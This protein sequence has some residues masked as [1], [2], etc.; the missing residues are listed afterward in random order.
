[1]RE[2]PNFMA[3]DPERDILGKILAIN[4]ED[5]TVKIRNLPKTY[6][7]M[8]KNCWILEGTQKRDVTG[9]EI[10]EGQ[11]LKIEDSITPSVGLSPGFVIHDLFVPVVW[12]EENSLWSFDIENDE[13]FQDYYDKEDSRAKIAFR[14]HVRTLMFDGSAEIVGNIFQNPE[15]L[16]EE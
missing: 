14:N 10:F 1:M 11:I 12:D 13:R 3:Y 5:K 6:W 16:K 4:F 7:E 8:Q 2:I 9:A 15:L